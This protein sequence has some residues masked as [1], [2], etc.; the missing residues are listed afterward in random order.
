MGLERAL[1]GTALGRIIHNK[2]P[3]VQRDRELLLKFYDSICR[4]FPWYTPESPEALSKLSNLKLKALNQRVWNEQDAKAQS[5]YMKILKKEPELVIERPKHV[6]YRNLIVP[7][8]LQ[9]E[10]TEETIEAVHV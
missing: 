9:I 6:R 7:Q 3:K 8:E 5:T 4:A 10:S 2:G 1:G